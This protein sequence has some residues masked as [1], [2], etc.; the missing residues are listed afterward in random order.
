MA[1]QRNGAALFRLLD[2]Q[3]RAEA[4]QH[5]LRMVAGGLGLDHGGFADDD[6]RAVVEHDA[7]ADARGRMDIDGKCQRCL[8]GQGECE[9]PAPVLPQRVR[10]AVRL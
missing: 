6:S 1:G 2:D 10:D 9:F 8:A 5:Q 3:L 4:L 7:A